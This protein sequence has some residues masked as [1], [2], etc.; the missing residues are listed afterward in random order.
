MPNQY[1]NA[2]YI[3]RK[4]KRLAEAQKVVDKI[5]ADPSVL[6]A[7]EL[8][9]HPEVKKLQASKNKLY[10]FCRPHQDTFYKRRR[11]ALKG[12]E[13]EGTSR[14]GKGTQKDHK[15]YH[16]DQ[17]MRKVLVKIA[18]KFSG[19][20]LDAI[21]NGVRF[22]PGQVRV[23]VIDFSGERIRFTVGSDP[24]FGS[25]RSAEEHWLNMVAETKKEKSDFVLVPGDVTNGMD[26][27][28]APHYEQSHIGYAA[29]KA[30]AIQMLSLLPVKT[31]V[32]AGNHDLWYKK[33]NSAEIV[34]DICKE[35]KNCVYLG[36]HE[37]DI[38]LK[39]R[40]NLKMFHGQDGSSYA[41]S[42]RLQKILESLPGGEKP[43][44]LVAGH[45]H[46]ALYIYERMVHTLS[47][48]AM[49]MQT[50][51]MRTKRLASHTGFWIVDVWVNKSGVAKFRPCWH[52]FYA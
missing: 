20:E 38:N 2:H 6:S 12:Y 23:P 25:M 43:H 40:V 21:A 28:K 11:D 39:G 27:Q 42:Y 17:R 8:M 13:P 24:H 31:Y 47:A 45:A 5:A 10:D 46:K 41:L 32:I 49:Q 37:G 22:M 14:Y 29:Q 51:W 15:E 34:P 36:E 52:P 33:Q 3:E 50:Q 9:R 19:A 1:Q 26:T 16:A 4:K 35:V 48:G 44:I 18:E 30:R 7:A